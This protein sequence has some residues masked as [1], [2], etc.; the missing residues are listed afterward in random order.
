LERAIASV[1]AQ[2]FTD[3][4]L[5]VVDDGSIDDTAARVLRLAQAEPRI[6]YVRQPNQGPAAARNTGIRVADGKW[7]AFLDSDDE[8]EPTYLSRRFELLTQRPHLHAVWGGIHLIGPREKQYVPDMKRPGKKIH[9][10]KCFVGG[11]LVAL[12]QCLL[13]VGDFR[14]ITYGEDS[15]LFLRLQARFATE[16]VQDRRNTGT[17]ISSLGRKRMFF[18]RVLIFPAETCRGRKHIARVRNYSSE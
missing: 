6:L 4:Q 16:W 3:W 12:R 1:L 18:V 7:V 13:E 2:E 17:V 10:S 5:V 9:L 8:Y 15:E 11:T 14:N